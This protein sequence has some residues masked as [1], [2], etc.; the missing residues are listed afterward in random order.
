MDQGGV[1]KDV[2][3][4]GFVND[5]RSGV[6]LWGQ[7]SHSTSHCCL[8][9]YTILHT[10]PRSFVHSTDTRRLGST[11]PSGTRSDLKASEQGGKGSACARSNSAWAAT[12]P[13]SSTGL[14]EEPKNLN[15]SPQVPSSRL[16]SAFARI[17]A[18]R[19]QKLLITLRKHFPRDNKPKLDE[20]SPKSPS[21]IT[22][23]SDEDRPSSLVPR[24][25]EGSIYCSALREQLP[26]STDDQPT[27]LSSQQCSKDHTYRS[28]GEKY[29]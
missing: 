4:F 1:Q 25:L 8:I 21:L 15:P 14:E 5:G 26:S 16:K 7:Y 12:E 29:Q 22:S 28:A 20:Q 11:V 19:A 23:N 2:C 3:Q 13:A 27:G 9:Q 10:M 24:E 17:K 6:E 18:E